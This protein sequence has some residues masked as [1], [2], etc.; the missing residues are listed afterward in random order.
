[1]VGVVEGTQSVGKGG[2]FS[3]AEDSSVH[4]FDGVRGVRIIG[5]DG[6]ACTVGGEGGAHTFG[7]VG[8]GR[9]VGEV[10]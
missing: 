4:T 2:G 1:M 7:G 6:G 8:S 3:I 10:G 5:G 9:T